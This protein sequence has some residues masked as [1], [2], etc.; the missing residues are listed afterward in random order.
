MLRMGG[1]EIRG[2]DTRGVKL[3]RKLNSSQG[4]SDSVW[5]KEAMGDWGE[6]KGDGS[7]ESGTD[8]T[9][10]LRFISTTKYSQNFPYGPGTIPGTGN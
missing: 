4:R 3:G 9:S 7:S 2:N 1:R 8:S 5:M 10:L 6:G